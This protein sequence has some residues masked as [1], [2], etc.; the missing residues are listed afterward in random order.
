M[1]INSAVLSIGIETP[2]T[3]F[4]PPSTLILRVLKKTSGTNYQFM[5]SYIDS[6]STEMSGFFATPDGKYY[7][8]GG[9]ASSTPAVELTYD[10]NQQRYVGHLSLFLQN[11]FDKKKGDIDLLYLGLFPASPAIGKSVDRVV[12]NQDDIKLEI[13]YTTPVLQNLE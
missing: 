11:L 8:A 4:S 1:I 5:N 3:G 6:D 9:D 7:L 12:F 10:E 2:P 13:Y